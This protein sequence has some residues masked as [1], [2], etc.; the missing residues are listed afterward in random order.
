[1][2]VGAG[3]AIEG[4][5]AESTFDQQWHWRAFVVLLTGFGLYGVLYYHLLFP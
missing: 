3:G 1:M 5:I 2:G 4:V